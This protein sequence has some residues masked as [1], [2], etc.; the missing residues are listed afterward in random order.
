MDF[1]AAE[2][3]LAMRQTGCPICRL[4]DEAEYGYLYFLLYENVN[5]G[6]TRQQIVASLDFCSQHT[7]Q[8]GRIETRKFGQAMGNS[9]IYES[10]TAIVRDHLARIHD[11]VQAERRSRWR[12]GWERW[13]ERLLHRSRRL[14]RL[15]A[16]RPQAPCRVC[17]IGEQTGQAHLRWLLE[18]LAQP[19]SDFRNWYLHSDRLC[20]PHLRRALE[21][22]GPETEAGMEFLLCDALGY[23]TALRADL[24]EYVGKQ[25]W[26]RRVEAMTEAEKVSWLKALR[27]FGGNERSQDGHRPA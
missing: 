26:D 6:S 7:W 23:L 15:D 17:Q 19:Q 21:L 3:R 4:R 10:L 16:I 24:D 13:W 14:P 12:R 20:F 2:L 8:M 18:G 5:D 9:I 11:R 27:F 25:A 1:I 22:A